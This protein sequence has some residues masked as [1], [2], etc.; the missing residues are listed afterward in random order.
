M[1]CPKFSWTSVQL[2]Y[3]EKLLAKASNGDEAA[4]REIFDTYRNAIYSYS[5]YVL[6][7]ELLAEDIVQDVFLKI[8]IGRQKL[9]TVQSFNSWLFIV[10]R[11]K[12]VD[13]FKEQLRQSSI[14]RKAIVNKE[15]EDIERKIIQRDYETL[16]HE[17]VDRLTPQQ[18][19]I[20]HLSREEGLKHREIALKLNIS[21]NTVKEHLV[22]ALRSIRKFLTPYLS[23]LILFFLAK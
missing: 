5:M 8:W 1:S 9:A 2:L 12:I 18:Q 4:F 14:I 3:E 21:P 13:V 20:Y 19:L 17:A 15:P 22:Q 10:V 16:L 7:N 6:K 11:N 23:L